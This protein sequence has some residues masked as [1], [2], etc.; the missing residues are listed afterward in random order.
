M[1]CTLVK[2]NTIV[3]G[4]TDPL[5]NCINPQMYNRDRREKRKTV[6]KAKRVGE[7]VKKEARWKYYCL[8]A[9]ARLN[10]FNPIINVKP[11]MHTNIIG[12]Y[13]PSVRKPSFTLR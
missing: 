3:G 1:R 9:L 10:S 8:D 2:T 5:Y 13:N 7:K 6:G 11:Y 12:H 4:K